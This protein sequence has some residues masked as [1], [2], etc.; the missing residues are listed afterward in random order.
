M[1][2]QETNEIMKEAR[3]TR[4]PVADRHEDGFVSRAWRA[5]SNLPGK[6]TGLFHRNR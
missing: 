1:R 2:I 6:L 4:Q 3:Y 5:V